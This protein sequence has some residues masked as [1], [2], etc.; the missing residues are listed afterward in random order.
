MGNPWTVAP[1]VVTLNLSWR[2]PDGE[3]LPFWVKIKKFLTVGEERVVQTAGWKGVTG[4]SGEGERGD[5]EIRIDWKATSFARAVAYLVDWSLEDD[6]HNRMPLTSNSLQALHPEVFELIE[7]A[8]TDHTK[9]M[10]EEK[11]ARAGSHAPVPTSA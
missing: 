1:E 3:D 8:I 5:A 4:L 2:T 6:K 7:N 9:A 10:A 11:K